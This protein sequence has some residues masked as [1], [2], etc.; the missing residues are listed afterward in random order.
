VS[1][2]K[3]SVLPKEGGGAKNTHQ[4]SEL[5]NKPLYHSS[6]DYTDRPYA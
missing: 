1:A 6:D 3:V 2:D 5:R 4:F